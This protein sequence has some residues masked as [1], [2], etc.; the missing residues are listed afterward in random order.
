MQMAIALGQHGVEE[1]AK[2]KEAHPEIEARSF[3]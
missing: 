3:Y 1:L 2:V